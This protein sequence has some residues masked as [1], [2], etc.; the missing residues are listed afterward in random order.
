MREAKVKR[1]PRVTQKIDPEIS[2]CN[3]ETL[4]LPRQSDGDAFCVHCTGGFRA[5]KSKKNL[6]M[7]EPV[8]DEGRPCRK[9]FFAKAELEV[10]V[11]RARLTPIAFQSFGW[12]GGSYYSRWSP[13]IPS[14]TNHLVGPST[15]WNNVAANLSKQRSRTEPQNMKTPTPEQITKIFDSRTE[16]EWLARSIGLSLRSMD[17]SVEQIAEFYHEQLVDLMADGLVDGRQ[18]SGTMDQSLF[19][20]VHSF[21]LHL[22]AA[23]D[24]LAALIAVRIGKDPRTIDSM[25]RLID[26]L[27][28]K[29]VGTDALLNL[30]ETRKFIQPAS[31]NPNRREMSGWLKKVSDLRNQF[32]HRR[33]Y[34][35]RHVEGAGHLVAIVPAKGLYRYV[36]P[37]L[38]ENDAERD[39]LDVIVSH[40]KQATALFQDAAETSG[41]DTSMLTLTDKDIVSIDRRPPNSVN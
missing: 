23:R 18:S 20:H 25:A 22:G 5:A 32:V 38:V 27:R 39:I 30:L 9:G 37:V 28:P 6:W 17:I 36:R 8:M 2:I 33:P 35:A 29:H 7:I 15:L 11:R 19:A 34:G 21:F 3:D 41:L 24:Y 10:F 13:L 4:A 40:Y 31:A 26:T 14:R 16:E 1:L 12:N